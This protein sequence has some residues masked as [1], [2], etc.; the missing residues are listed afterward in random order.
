VTAAGTFLLALWACAHVLI[1]A[2]VLTARGSR[3]I[4]GLMTLLMVV[5]YVLKPYTYDLDKYSI[6]F[7]TGFIAAH[8]WHSPN[9]F[10]QLDSLDTNGEPFAQSFETGFRWL[11][12]LGS[13]ALPKGSLVPRFD[14]D[15]GDFQER[16][17]P[18][19]DAMI[20][21]I[22]GIGLGMLLTSIRF[23]CMLNN[24][25]SYPRLINLWQTVPIVLGSVF[26][27]LGSQNVLRQFLG[28]A[29]VIL[30]ISAINSKRYLVA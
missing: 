4:L 5:A 6:F 12:K 24:S 26:F 17:P 7:H 3:A 11:A 1:L 2:V 21:L 22:M 16:G 9:N 14:E 19:S 15:Y 10:F 30:A 25:G 18:R 27:L 23:L 29:I 28:V 13:L 8:S 20:F